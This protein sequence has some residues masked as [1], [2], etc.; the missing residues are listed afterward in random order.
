MSIK[1]FKSEQICL[2]IFS[3]YSHEYSNTC[4]LKLKF[5]VRQSHF[6]SQKCDYGRITLW[7]KPSFRKEFH[8]FQNPETSAWIR[9]VSKFNNNEMQ[10]HGKKLNLFVCFCLGIMMCSLLTNIF[11]NPSFFIS[12]PLLVKGKG[13]SQLNYFPR[14]KWK[15]IENSLKC[16]TDWI[17]LHSKVN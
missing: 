4:T 2:S 10:K 3:S 6:F 17:L 9:I 11:Q 13:N 1:T 7:P 15:Q 16:F 14:T 8:L 12:T 5:L